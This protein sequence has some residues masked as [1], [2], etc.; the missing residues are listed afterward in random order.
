MKEEGDS[1]LQVRRE[2]GLGLSTTQ[3]DS[4]EQQASSGDKASM[5][6][7]PRGVGVEP[8]GDPAHA[9]TTQAVPS[10]EHIGRYK[11]SCVWVLP[12]DIVVMLYTSQLPYL[13]FN[14]FSY[15]N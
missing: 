4:S 5:C 14:F 15:E 8:S 9:Q 6:G 2:T 13:C 11:P 10:E 1:D 3:G 7:F 12:L